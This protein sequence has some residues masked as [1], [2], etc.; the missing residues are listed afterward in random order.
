[1]A[2]LACFYTSRDRR[3]DFGLDYATISPPDY[4]LLCTKFGT[5]PTLEEE[6][7]PMTD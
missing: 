6:E 3:P 7:G 2:E 5:L 1:M 4:P